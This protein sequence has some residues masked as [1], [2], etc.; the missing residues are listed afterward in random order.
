MKTVTLLSFSH[1]RAGNGAAIAAYIRRQLSDCRILEFVMDA[2]SCQPCHNCDYQCLQTGADCPN[3]KGTYYEALQAVCASDLT[4]FILPNYCGFPCAS[5]FAFNERSVGFFHGDEA[6]LE[7]Y[8]DAPKRFIIISNTESQIFTE[9]M[10]Q[11]VSQEPQILYL[12][13]K[14]YRKQSINGDILASNQAQID[15][16]SFL[17]RD[18]LSCIHYTTEPRPTQQN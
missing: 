17:H 12:K 10:Q 1:R 14:N 11:Q 8:L 2:D 18:F 4:Y 15:L 5:Y 16:A 6:V 7:R 13:S 3:Q 9:A